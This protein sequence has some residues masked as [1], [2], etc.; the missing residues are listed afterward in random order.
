MVIK[1]GYKRLFPVMLVTVMLCAGCATPQPTKINT[2]E[3]PVQSGTIPTTV[4]S[5]WPGENSRNSFFQ[6]L[7]A[8]HI[9]DIVTVMVSEKTSAVKEATTSTSRSTAHDI[10]LGANLGL[11][12]NLGINDL[13]GSNYK[14]DPNVASGYDSSFDGTGKTE[15]SGELTAVISTRIVDVLPNGNLVIE[16]KKDTILNKELQ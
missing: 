3:L 9:G 15:R 13:L 12:T 8:R 1:D 11:P 2:S 10:A 6:D 14:L 7:R 4:G 16:G 5:I